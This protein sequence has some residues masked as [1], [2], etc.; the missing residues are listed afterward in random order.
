MTSFDVLYGLPDAV[1]REAIGE[2]FRVLKPGGT[3]IVNVAALESLRGNHSVLS[4]EVRRYSKRDLRRRPRG[5][6]IPRHPQHLHQLHDSSAGRGD[7]AEAALERTRGVAGR[8]HDPG[9]PGQRALS[10]L[11]A[12]EAAALRVMNM[13][14][15]SSLLAVATKP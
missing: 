13:P 10:G 4:G 6:G 3:L 9:G 14:V 2:M 12:I 1:E 8:D 15:G 7:Q 5:R 11:L